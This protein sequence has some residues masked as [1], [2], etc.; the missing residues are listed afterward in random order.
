MVWLQSPILFSH[1]FEEMQAKNIKVT[2]L[3]ALWFI[4]FLVSQGDM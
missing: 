4:Q 2:Y 1:Y 3:G